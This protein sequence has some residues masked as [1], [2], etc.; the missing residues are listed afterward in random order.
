[1]AMRRMTSRAP[2]LHMPDWE[3]R[4]ALELTSAFPSSPP[5]RSESVVKSF[6]RRQAYESL[7]GANPRA[8][9]DDLWEF[10]FLAESSGAT[11]G[12]GKAGRD[13]I[14]LNRRCIG[15]RRRW[16]S[17]A[18]GASK[19][20]MRSSAAPKLWRSGSVI[21][22]GRAMD[23]QTTARTLEGPTVIGGKAWT[24][25]PACRSAN[26][27]IWSWCVNRITWVV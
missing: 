17:P 20:D 15:W 1:M 16:G 8:A 5:E 9:N 24:A 26:D 7:R 25:T 27:T 13:V 19:S 2:F 12:S 6:G 14:G 23:T 10:V 18:K 21:R 11:T 3:R 22:L 4:L